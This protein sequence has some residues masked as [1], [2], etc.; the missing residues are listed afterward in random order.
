VRAAARV[1]LERRG[2][3]GAVRELADIILSSAS[4]DTVIS[5]VPAEQQIGSE[6]P[7]QFQLAE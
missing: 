5:T 6:Q 2:G 4:S 1:V 3:A 7:W